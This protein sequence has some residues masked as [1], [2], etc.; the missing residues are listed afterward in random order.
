MSSALY[1]ENAED[2]H[3]QATKARTAESKDGWL[4]IA[5]EWQK[6]ADE[7]DMIQASRRE[8]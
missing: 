3:E 2:C 6:L 4:R 7:M 5:E 8:R 1:R